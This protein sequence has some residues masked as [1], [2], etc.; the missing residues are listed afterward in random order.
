M[1]DPSDLFSNSLRACHDIHGT[2]QDGAPGHSV[3]LRGFRIL[4]ERETVFRFDRPQTQRAVRCNA[5][6]NDANRLI[7]FLVRQRL[8]E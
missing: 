3:V 8:E 5:R 1:G 4:G 6:K 2:R 7:L